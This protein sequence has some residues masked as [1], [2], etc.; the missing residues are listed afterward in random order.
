MAK[1]ASFLPQNVF[2]QGKNT[3]F[4]SRHEH[5]DRGLRTCTQKK[6][7]LAFNE[8]GD[9]DA[10]M[11]N[12]PGTLKRISNKPFQTYSSTFVVGIH[13]PDLQE[14]LNSYCHRNAE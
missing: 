7:D 1:Y 13:E 8:P 4:A 3:V 5:R 11:A 2:P 6:A 9:V 14:I 10:F 12:N